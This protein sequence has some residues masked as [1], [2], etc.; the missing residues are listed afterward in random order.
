M[1]T[2]ARREGPDRGRGSVIAQV[3]EEYPAMAATF[4][5]VKHKPVRMILGKHSANI[6]CELLGFR[7]SRAC[8][9][10]LKGSDDVQSFS[11]CGLAKAVQAKQLQNLPHFFCRTHHFAEFNVR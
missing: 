10:V 1:G 9:R 5:H 3:V 8:S 11:A 2:R 7:P 4:R 6:A